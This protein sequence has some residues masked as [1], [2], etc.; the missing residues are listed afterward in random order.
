MTGKEKC[1]ILKKIRQ[2]IANENGIE[3][4]TSECKHK[5]ECKGTCPKCEAELA[6]LEK[7]LRNKKIAIGATVA[8]GAISVSL[9]GAVIASNIISASSSQNN[10]SSS[11]AKTEEVYGG[12][13]GETTMIST[14]EFT[15]SGDVV[16]YPDD[17][18]LEGEAYIEDDSLTEEI[19]AT[20]EELAGSIVE[21][22]NCEYDKFQDTEEK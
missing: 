1:K 22:P 3:I 12:M 9:G 17:T 16:Y 2:E 15:L 11:T 10:N 14:E 20:I 13:E 18:E 4:V 6:Y 19:T 7:E 8:L 5:G 21:D